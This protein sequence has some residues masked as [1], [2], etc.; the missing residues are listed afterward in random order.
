MKW[1]TARWPCSIWLALLVPVV[2]GQDKPKD[3]VVTNFAILVGFP[4]GSQNAIDGIL[5]IPGTVIP[6][7]ADE[8]TPAEAGKTDLLG[9]SLSFTK[10]VDRLWS[11]FRLDTSRQIQKGLRA[12]TRVGEAVGLPEIEGSNVRMTAVLL[13]YSNTTATYRVV[14]KQGEKPLADSTV[15]ATRGGRTVVGGTDGELA[16]YLFVI[17]EPE[18]A[19]ESQG[20][21]DATSK[22]PGV[23]QPVLVRK[24][25]PKYPEEAKKNKV[26][27]VVVLNLV[28]DMQGRVEDVQAVENPDDSLTKAAM[29]AV[30][31]W[32]FRPARDA[33]G[34]PLKVLTTITLR[35]ELK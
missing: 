12:A 23:T 34:Q 13:G 30:R 17:L 27:G 31:Q 14:F 1:F 15:I 7:A 28:V 9:K 10:V 5:L 8:I 21:I 4:S 25:A 11:T 20:G 19:G 18:R 35:F 6:L 26:R 33:K 22:N 24:V 32:E 16:P 3:V 29:D 2:T